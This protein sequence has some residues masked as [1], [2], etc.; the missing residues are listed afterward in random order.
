MIA[1]REHIQKNIEEAIRAKQEL[2]NHLEDLE[3]MGRMLLDCF[4]NGGKLVLFGNGGSA[5]D[6]QHIAA[7]FVWLLDQNKKRPGIHAV[8]LTTNTSIITAVSNDL[9]YE[10]LFSRQVESLVNKGDVAIGISTSGNSGN[11]IKGLAA[12]KDKGAKTI[13]WTGRDGG[14]MKSLPLDF[15]FKAPSDNVNRIQEIH[16]TAGHILCSAVEKEMHDL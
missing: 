1:I 6:S 4:I 5:A 15:H 8:A 3:D 9:G 12:A 2:A 13:G 16:I 10:Q 14:K 7:E 11:V